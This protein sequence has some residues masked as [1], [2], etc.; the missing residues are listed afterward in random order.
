MF[1]PRRRKRSLDDLSGL[2]RVA[3]A[4]NSDDGEWV[5]EPEDLSFDE[6]VGC[7]NYFGNNQSELGGSKREFEVE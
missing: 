2:A 5:W 3:V 1:V 4:V 7:Y 6:P